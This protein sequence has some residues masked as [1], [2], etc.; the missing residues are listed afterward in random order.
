MVTDE[1]PQN[2]ILMYAVGASTFLDKS[3]LLL[4]VDYYYHSSCNNIERK[5]GGKRISNAEH[6]MLN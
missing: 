1:D 2:F 6:L 4:L 5:K 3:L